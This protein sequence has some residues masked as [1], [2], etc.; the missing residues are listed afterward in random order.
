VS[1]GERATRTIWGG[2]WVRLISSHNSVPDGAEGRTH[3][4]RRDGE[5]LV[6]LADGRE[7]YLPVAL[8]V[9]VDRNAIAPD[10]IS[11]WFRDIP[12]TAEVG[13]VNTVVSREVSDE[14]IYEVRGRAKRWYVVRIP[15]GESAPEQRTRFFQSQHLAEEALGKLTS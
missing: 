9:R 15:K 7:V 8:L 6:R 3:G 14:Y 1:R 2:S 5:T 12:P 11:A 13:G 4:R 10:H